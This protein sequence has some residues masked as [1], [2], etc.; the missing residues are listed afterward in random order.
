[1]TGT[2]IEESLRFRFAWPT[3]HDCPLGTTHVVLH[4]QQPWENRSAWRFLSGAAESKNRHARSDTSL[5]GHLT[6]LGL[7]CACDKIEL[8]DQATCSVAI[9]TI[10]G[11][12]RR[13][14]GIC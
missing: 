13:S 7:C 6:A 3:T 9:W 8:L 5:E 4:Y 2:S 1:M 12:F 10:L 14:A 11:G